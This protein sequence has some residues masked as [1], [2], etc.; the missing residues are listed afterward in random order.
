M[1]NAFAALLVIV[2]IG[3]FAFAK[4]EN[5]QAT[6][7]KLAVTKDGFEPKTIDVKPGTEVT[8]LVTRKTESTCAKKIQIPSKNVKQDLPLN[9]EV[10]IQ[11]GKL[12]K[13]EIRF[14]C[15]MMME[16]GQ[17]NVR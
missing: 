10:S 6:A 12:D 9:K 17:I 8:L 7:I 16:T 13:G 2:T 15:G 5:V 11:L 1:K 4:G 14:G 3:S